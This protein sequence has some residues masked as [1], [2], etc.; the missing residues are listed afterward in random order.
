MTHF[1]ST[2]WVNGRI[3]IAVSR[4]CSQMICGAWL[5][6]P[7]REREPEWD[8]GSGYQVKLQAR[9]TPRTSLQTPPSHTGEPPRTAPPLPKHHAVPRAETQVGRDIGVKS[10][11]IS[12]KSKDWT[13]NR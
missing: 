13:E 6:S 4:S 3:A 7:L 10:R 2:G 8:P 1:E 5:P 12:V 9:L 11:D